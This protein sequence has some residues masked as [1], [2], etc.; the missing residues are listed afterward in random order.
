M[1][2]YFCEPIGMYVVHGWSH[3]DEK[4]RGYGSVVELAHFNDEDEAFS[5]MHRLTCPEAGKLANVRLLK[6]AKDVLENCQFPV[7]AMKTKEE[8]IDVIKYAEGR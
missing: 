1:E 3:E 4:G 8:L 5:Y 2:C 6:V 7:G